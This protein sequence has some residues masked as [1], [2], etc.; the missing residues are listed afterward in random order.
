MAPEQLEGREADARTD[1]FA[2]GALIYEMATG[3]KAFE[4]KS[5]ASLISSIMSAEPQPISAV[6][7]MAPPALDRVVKSCLAKDP[8]DRWQ[9]AHDV[10]L[11]LKW[12][13]EGGS[14][15]GISAPV[16][17][18]RKS[19]DRLAWAV[20]TL[21]AL[22]TL[23]LGVAYFGR[24]SAPARIVRSFI[25]PPEKATFHLTGFGAGPVAVS[26]DGLTL[27]FTAKASEG[28]D[29]LWIR[30]L[31]ALLARPLSGTEGASYP[32]WS[33]DSKFVG[34]FAE[35]KLKKIS[36][37]GGPA[38]TLCD[39]PDARGGTWNRAGVILFEPEWRAPIYRVPAAGGTP[40]PVTQFDKSRGETTH[41][42]PY[43]LPDGRHFLYLG[44]TH[45]QGVKSE[46]NAIFLASLD[47]PERRLLVNARS[48]AAYGEGFLLFVREKT[49]LAQPFDPNRQE[50]SGDPVPVVEKVQYDAGY[51]TAI[52]SASENGVLAYQADT[53]STSLSQL[54]WLDRSGKRVGTVGA[55]ADYWIP[56]LSHDG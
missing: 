38:L 46:A 7:P 25:L 12:I 26:P 33:P 30:S 23:A 50:L 10:Q 24:T 56:R 8:D 44:G 31:D 45:S 48:N 36:V 18:R 22:S 9:T 6:H 51:F 42:W 32:F 21:L 15:L 14:Q 3:R 55:P 41:R 11:Q 40:Q 39:A 49:L 28:K 43:F 52:F 4:G 47:S 2:L 1:I 19:R 54:V 27:V 20:A 5:Q 53:G 16:A 13:A 17:A 34:F 29:L 35:G 37:A